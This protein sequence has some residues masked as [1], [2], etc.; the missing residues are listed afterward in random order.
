MEQKKDNEIKNLDLKKTKKKI[1]P[2]VFLVVLGIALGILVAG[3]FGIN[4]SQKEFLYVHRRC[5]VNDAT[6]R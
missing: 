3:S 2:N 5:L 4:F 1:N 6:Q